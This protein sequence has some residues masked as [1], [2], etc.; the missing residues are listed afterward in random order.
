MMPGRLGR[1]WHLSGIEEYRGGRPSLA[2]R[3]PL[4]ERGGSFA[5]L[6]VSAVGLT[7]RL[8]SKIPQCPPTAPSWMCFHGSS[9]GSKIRRS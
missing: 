8:A 4:L 2:S 3:R 5:S 9:K 1:R 7:L 6:N